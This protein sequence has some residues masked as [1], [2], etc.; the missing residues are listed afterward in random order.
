MSFR[1]IIIK[2]R[3]KLE[4][5]LN[6]LV[7]RKGMDETRV[8]IDEISIIVIDSTQVSLT[9]ALISELSK[10]KVRIIFCDEQHNPCSEVVPYQNNYYSYRKI[11]EQ[12]AVTEFTKKSLWKYIIEEKID[13]QSRVLK[14]L[15]QINEYELLQ[16]YKNN[17]DVGDTSNREGHAAKVY[18]NALFGKQF[19]RNQD[20]DINKF[21]NY[22]YS[23]ILSSISREIKMYGYLTELGIHHIGESNNFNLSCDFIEPLRPLVDYL[24]VTNQVNNDN[25]KVEFIKM[26][27]MNVSYRD[28]SFLLDNAIHLYV[29]NLIDRMSNGC[30]NKMDFIKYEL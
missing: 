28:C 8:L 13:C 19:N 14:H 17:V 9:T 3:C 26:L 1:N 22:G 18:F 10:S 25:F 24:V 29:G 11:K 7:C 12:M 6:Y 27:S 23:I 2:D 16:S 21:L 5:S 15:D 30:L 20:N 4:Y